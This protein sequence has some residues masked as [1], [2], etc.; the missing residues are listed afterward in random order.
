MITLQELL[1]SRDARAAHQREL[2]GAH[3]GNSLI[4]LTVQLPG[5]EKRNAQSL[6]I[7]NAGVEAIQKAFHPLYQELKD[8]ETGFEGYFLVELPA[9]KAKMTACSIEDSHPLGRLMDIDVVG[10]DG[11]KIVGREEIGLPARR[12]LLCDNEVRYCMRAKT[13]TTQELLDCINF[14][15]REYELQGSKP[16]SD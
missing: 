9:E 13:H 11:F 2:L 12:C 5:S 10:P 6:K 4:C 16:G 15:V 7:A 1:D 3:P 14:K 8:L